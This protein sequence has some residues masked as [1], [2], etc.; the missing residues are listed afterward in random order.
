MKRNDWLFLVNA[1]LFVDICSIAALGLLLAFVI[2]SGHG[3]FGANYFLGVHRHAWGDFHLY[4]SLT[5]LVLVFVHLWLNWK[6][7]VQTTRR[8]FGD[9]WKK[10]LGWLSCAWLPILII[11]WIVIKLS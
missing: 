2:P 7:I 6:W 11:G 4:L 8:Y 3:S 5:L 10:A 9:Y 1:L